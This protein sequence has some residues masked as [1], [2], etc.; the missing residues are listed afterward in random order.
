[1]N[2][3]IYNTATSALWV[4]MQAISE[5][6][7]GNSRPSHLS[8]TQNGL[9]GLWLLLMATTTVPSQHT[10]CLL[11]VSKEAKEELTLL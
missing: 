1:M 6:L 9:Q 7:M 4:S 5:Y 11:A 2:R 3:L 8:V 10:H